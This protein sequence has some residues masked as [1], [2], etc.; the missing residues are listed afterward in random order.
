MTERKSSLLNELPFLIAFLYALGTVLPIIPNFNVMLAALAALTIGISF[1]TSNLSVGGWLLL[2]ACVS[3]TL[4]AYF[5]TDGPLLSRNEIAYFLIFGLY[6][7]YFVNNMDKLPQ[8]VRK[9]KKYLIAICVIWHLVVLVSF[10][11]TDSWAG[12]AVGQG[13]FESFAKDTFRLSPSA[14]LIMGISLLLIVYFRR[15]YVM[16]SFLPMLT[17]LL[18]A[19]RTYLVVGVCLMAVVLYFG[20]R[21]KLAYT[22]VLVILGCLATIIVLNSAMG[23]KILT[24]LD[25]DAY[26][27]PLAQFT[28]SRSNFWEKDMEAFSDVSFLRKVFGCGYNFIREQTAS[29]LN[30]DGL[31][32]HNDYIQALLTFG[33]VGLFTYLGFAFMLF[34]NIL[35]KRVPLLLKIAI[36]FI[37]FFNAMFNMVY[38]YMCAVISLY[39]VVAAL[40]YYY[41]RRMPK[42]KKAVSKENA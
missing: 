15:Q 22:S 24:S 17:I 31:W 9:Y 20:I 35:K 30:P 19:S 8:F 25:D 27:D 42:K 2:F 12:G 26:L 40:D 3:E 32:A 41:N 11:L 28:S 21:N 36:L 13:S 34:K 23:Q 7:L 33:Y 37:W 38:T 1:L 16:Y 6:V 14:T 18:G 29:Y 5:V 39:L 4:L 10:P